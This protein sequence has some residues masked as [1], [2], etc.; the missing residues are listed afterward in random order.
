MAVKIWS[1]DLRRVP[2]PEVLAQLNRERV[3]GTLCCVRGSTTRSVQ[4]ADGNA[5]WAASSDPDESATN[6]RRPR[7]VV[8]WIE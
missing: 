7:T 4:I 3:N 8:R 6:D 2:L 1:G 5:F